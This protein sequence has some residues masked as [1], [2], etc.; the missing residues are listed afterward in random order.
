M[1]TRQLATLIAVASCS[2]PPAP[3]PAVM[4]AAA[5]AAVVD[6]VAATMTRWRGAINARDF[7]VASRF[8]S[9]DSAFRWYEDGELRYHTAVELGQAMQ[10]GAAAIRTID[11]SLIDVHITPLAPDAAAVTT[12]FTQKM[13]DTL[14]QVGGF[15]GAISMTM[16]HGAAGWQFLVGHT[17]SVVPIDSARTRGARKG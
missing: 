8:Y 16:V 11:F 9:A 3:A 5:R 15:A 14:G 6:S 12:E 7:A 1:K 4:T 17:S 10:A 2:A 13:T